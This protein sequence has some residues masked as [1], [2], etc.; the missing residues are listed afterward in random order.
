MIVSAITWIGAS[1]HLL[2]GLMVLVGAACFLFAWVMDI[3]KT[4]SEVERIKN[5]EGRLAFADRYCAHIPVVSGTLQYALEMVRGCAYGKPVRDVSDFKQ[6]ILGT[7]EE[8]P[9]C[10]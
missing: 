5:I 2:L 7:Q 10:L 9:Y 3:L 4:R 6:D 8:G 1:L